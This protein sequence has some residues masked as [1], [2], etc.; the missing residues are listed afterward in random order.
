VIAALDPLR[1][2]DLLR[3]C[4]QIDLADV[5]EEELQRVGRDLAHL[6]L[7]RALLLVRVGNVV[8]DLDLQL[9]ERVVEVVDLRGLEL[10][11]VESQRDV[12]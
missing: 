7:G 6:G 3:G 1:E 9:L 2:L 4:E 5:L 10:Q 12:A 11:L 8:D